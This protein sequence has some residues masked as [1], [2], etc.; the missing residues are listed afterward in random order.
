MGWVFFIEVVQ[1]GLI[2][3]V[4]DLFEGHSFFSKRIGGLVDADVGVKD[5]HGVV[6][7]HSVELL[8]YVL[9]QSLVLFLYF[10]IFVSYC[11]IFFVLKINKTLLE[12]FLSSE[13]ALDQFSIRTNYVLNLFLKLLS[14]LLINL[15]FLSV[16]LIYA[17]QTQ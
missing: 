2:S 1:D 12:F 8:P 5:S 7:W 11:A 6:G 4:A 10:M 16:F 15:F 17:V 13:L 14:L 9:L 3:L